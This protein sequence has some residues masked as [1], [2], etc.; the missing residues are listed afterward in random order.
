MTVFKQCLKTVILPS[1]N[2]YFADVSPLF[3]LIGAKKLPKGDAL[4]FVERYNIGI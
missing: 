3:A 1:K 2:T 4:Q